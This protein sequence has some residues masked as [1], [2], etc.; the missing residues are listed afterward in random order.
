MPRKKL[1]IETEQPELLTY[2]PLVNAEREKLAKLLDEPVFCKAWA[3]A[4]ASRPP[5]FPQ[6]LDSALG[7]QIASNRL[8]Q[9]QGW[10]MFKT[11]L[12]RQVSEPKLPRPVLE[13]TYPP[14]PAPTK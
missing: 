8:S 14:E 13:E 9:I 3:N 6:G 10:E 7:G 1:K 4:E 12:L 2:E 5:R 11:S